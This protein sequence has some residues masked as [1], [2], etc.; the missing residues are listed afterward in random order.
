MEEFDHLDGEEKLKAEN[1]F[2]KMKMMLEHGAQFGGNGNGE[3]SPELENQFLNYIMAFE[4]QAVAQKTIRLFDKI[5]RPQH[6][7]PVAEISDNDM[8]KALDEL[9][10]FLSE[11][12][13]SLDV[14]SPNISKRELYRFTIEELF[15]YEMDDM[16]IP[17]LK[18]NFIYD[19]FHPDPVYDNTR[20]AT[21]D[22]I[23]YILQNEPMEWTHHFKMG[24]LRLNQHYPLT[25]EQFKNLVN[26]F[27]LAY[28]SLE[29]ERIETDNLLAYTVLQLLWQ[30]NPYPFP[31]N[32][33]YNLSWMNKRVIGISQMLLLKA[34]CFNHSAGFKANG[35]KANPFLCLF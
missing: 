31:G 11:H 32:G 25:I 1:D 24:N 21:E 10:D 34:S 16:D 9:F 8:D 28:D 15:E 3:G 22:C 30:N 29:I 23:N 18:T 19:E 14:C 6:F 12:G 4:K 35:L 13:I 20:I 2:L 27:K 26:R 33:R 17:G 5:G 7:K